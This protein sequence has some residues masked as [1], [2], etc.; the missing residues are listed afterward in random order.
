MH[1]QFDGVCEHVAYKFIFRL[2]VGA[3][4]EHFVDHENNIRDPVRVDFAEYTLGHTL[5]ED[6]PDN[7]NGIFVNLRIGV[8]FG[9]HGKDVRVIYQ[10]A[11]KRIINGQVFHCLETH[12][13]KPAS[14]V[15]LVCNGLADL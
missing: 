1:Q 13:K 6:I 4:D 2:D 8:V 15:G 11:P 3:D 5:L 12:N 9:K 14:G 10:K 7:T